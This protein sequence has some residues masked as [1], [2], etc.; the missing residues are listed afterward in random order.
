M[1]SI[2]SG[3]YRDL[4]HL[5]VA[6]LLDISIVMVVVFHDLGPH[7]LFGRLERRHTILSPI[8][9]QWLPLLL[10]LIKTMSPT[11][12]VVGLVTTAS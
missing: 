3:S 11:I 8:H 10:Q 12:G 7:L 1:S 4:M 2:H 9:G 5:P 6:P